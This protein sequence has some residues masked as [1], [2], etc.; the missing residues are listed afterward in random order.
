[1]NPNPPLSAADQRAQLVAAAAP[2]QRVTWNIALPGATG[3]YDHRYSGILVRVIAADLAA[4]PPVTRQ[5]A[6]RL[7]HP[8]HAAGREDILPITI[9]GVDVTY[10]EVSAQQANVYLNDLRMQHVQ[11][12]SETP[13]VRNPSTWGMWIMVDLTQRPTANTN[14]EMWLRA[15]INLTGAKTSDILLPGADFE[16]LRVN[17]IVRQLVLWVRRAQ[18]DPNWQGEVSMAAVHEVLF[19][20][21][22]WDLELTYRRQRSG[23]SG[24][25]DGGPRHP[26]R[27]DAVRDWQARVAEMRKGSQLGDWDRACHVL[28]KKH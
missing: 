27:E 18:I 11:A 23:T 1:M 24:S 7:D 4:N 22:A 21:E 28:P 26:S 19:E 17:S 10:I 20:L 15:Q 9:A 12:G 2:G 14:F 8:V 6:V 25:K 3:T 5:V 16:G 13:T